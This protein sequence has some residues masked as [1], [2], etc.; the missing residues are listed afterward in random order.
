MDL[1]RTNTAFLAHSRAAWQQHGSVAQRSARLC[2]SS[3]RAE[4][5]VKIANNRATRA[6]ANRYACEG[7]RVG[8]M[9]LASAATVR[10]CS[11]AAVMLAISRYEVNWT[12]LRAAISETRRPIMSNRS[13]VDELPS[14]SLACY[15]FMFGEDGGERTVAAEQLERQYTAIAAAIRAN[16]GAVCADQLRPFLYDLPPPPTASGLRPRSCS[17]SKSGSCQLSHV[18]MGVQP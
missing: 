17:L 10:P 13:M 8:L 14:L 18:S 5:G 1:A 4:K 12:A 2:V 7:M 15:G 9:L 3:R 11:F 16:K 6:L